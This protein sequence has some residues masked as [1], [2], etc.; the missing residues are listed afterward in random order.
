M[1]TSGNVTLPVAARPAQK[2]AGL[3][4]PKLQETVYNPVPSFQW[5]VNA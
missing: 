3:R 4:R 2:A 1:G 5:P